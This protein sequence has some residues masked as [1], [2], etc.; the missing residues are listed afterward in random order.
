MKRLLILLF[1]FI[2]CSCEISEQN[3]HTYLRVPCHWE[4]DPH[5][6]KC[7]RN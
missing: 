5:C 3:K 6:G 4:H 1:P 2:L 7:K